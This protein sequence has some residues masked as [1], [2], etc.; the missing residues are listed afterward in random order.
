MTRT[1]LLAAAIATAA[2]LAPTASAGAATG[3]TLT[4]MRV[5]ASPATP[6]TL[7]AVARV[8]ARGWLTH[9][10][11]YGADGHPRRL[12]ATLRLARGGRTATARDTVRLKR[13]AHR[14]ATAL[15]HFTFPRAQ[16]RAIGSGTMRSRLRVGLEGEQQVP[17]LAPRGARQAQLDIPGLCLPPPFGTCRPTPAPAPAP[18]MPLEGAVAGAIASACVAFDG[19]N[20]RGPHVEHVS[21]LPFGGWNSGWTVES[22]HGAHYPLAADGTFSGEGMGTSP[23]AGGFVGMMYV[24]ISGTMS[25]GVLAGGAGT[26]IVRQSGGQL[27]SV[28]ADIAVSTTGGRWPNC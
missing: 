5:H 2:A 27:G 4:F 20:T 1:R 9:D 15:L 3:P 19:P 22:S 25:P 24:T 17:V 26:G 23:G 11:Q 21:F 6:G 16:A 8:S 18:P 14:G 10:Q 7:V 28:P 13:D 12:A